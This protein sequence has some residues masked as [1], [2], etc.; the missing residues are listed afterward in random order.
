MNRNL[1][2]W[3]LIALADTMNISYVTVPYFIT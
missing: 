3:I 1:A 2:A